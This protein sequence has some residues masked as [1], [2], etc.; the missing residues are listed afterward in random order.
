MSGSTSFTEAMALEQESV[1]ETADGNV[2]SVFTGVL[3][4][5]WTIGPKVHGG[6]ML[7][8]CANAARTAHGTGGQERSDRGNDT[9]GQE[10]SDTGSGE[11]S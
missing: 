6:V 11:N 5:N 10:R 9:G 3:N 2:C 8:L 4:E 7:A 1:S